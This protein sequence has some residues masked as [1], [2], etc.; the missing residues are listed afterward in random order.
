MTGKDIASLRLTHREK[1]LPFRATCETFLAQRFNVEFNAPTGSMRKFLEDNDGF[2]IW[3]AG[4]SMVQVWKNTPEQPEAALMDLERHININDPAWSDSDLDLYTN[5]N[6]HEENGPL[7]TLIKSWG[8]T[9]YHKFG[10]DYTS[11]FMWRNKIHTITSFKRLIGGMERQIQVIE[12]EPTPTGRR[13]IELTIDSFD[14]TCC[15]VG[16]N[17]RTK[18]F[19]VSDDAID[20]ITNE[21]MRLRESYMVKYSMANFILHKR[22]LKYKQRGFLF[23]NPPPLTLAVQKVDRS[24]RRLEMRINSIQDVLDALPVTRLQFVLRGYPFFESKIK[25]NAEDGEIKTELMQYNTNSVIYF[26]KYKIR[27]EGGLFKNTRFGNVTP[28]TYYDL[29]IRRL[30]FVIQKLQFLKGV[31][32]SGDIRAILATNRVDAMNKEV[33]RLRRLIAKTRKDIEEELQ[34]FNRKIITK[35]NELL[36]EVPVNAVYNQEDRLRLHNFERDARVYQGARF[37]A[38]ECEHGGEPYTRE[39]IPE[40]YPDKRKLF[41][42]A[43]YLP[44]VPPRAAD[45]DP[46]ISDDDSED[47]VRIGVARCYDLFS[48]YYDNDRRK[49]QGREEQYPDDRVALTEY[50]KILLRY[51]NSKK[52]KE[53]EIAENQQQIQKLLEKIDSPGKRSRLGITPVIDQLTINERFQ[54]LA[55]GET[56]SKSKSKSKKYSKSKSKSKSKRSKKSKYKQKSPRRIRGKR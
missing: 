54:I 36:F 30:E 47:V 29:S 53:D 49:S 34:G 33:E 10:A 25:Y 18:E 37:A 19:Y 5:G 23:L 11:G 52:S 3:A 39:K 50:E 27:T 21:R 31:Y 24:I 45:A 32:E 55:G 17:F 28:R 8:Y 26:A 46:N 48:L 16:Y 12:I 38:F 4:S 7:F 41:R 56:K 40:E 15:S 2:D 6:P 44:R 1:L 14:L 51:L 22:V 42:R 13:P 35:R 9:F 43:V 20:D